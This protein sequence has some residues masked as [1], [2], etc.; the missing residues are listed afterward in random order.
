MLLSSRAMLIRPLAGATVVALVL[1]V[2][3]AVA[4][5]TYTGNGRAIADDTLV[6][7]GAKMRLDGVEPVTA[8]T[9]DGESLPCR[10]LGKQALKRIISGRPVTCE[11]TAKVG[12]GS[13]VGRCNLDGDGG[14]VAAAMIAKGWLKATAGAAAD[15][16]EATETARAN[17]V[18]AWSAER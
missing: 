10:D 2:G 17:S 11:V 14:D 8:N 9:C 13:Y 12:H 7:R 16:V 6:V 5:D 3:A 18:G 4:A 15:Y 1:G